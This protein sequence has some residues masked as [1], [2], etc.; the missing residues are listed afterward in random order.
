MVGWVVFNTI[1]GWVQGA[2]DLARAAALN[3]E[4]VSVLLLGRDGDALI[5]RA[6]WHLL[7]RLLPVGGG[8]SLAGGAQRIAIGLLLLELIALLDV[9]VHL[10]GLDLLKC[11]LVVA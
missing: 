9:Q 11:H 7:E 2:F 3:L 6:W 10:A 4:Q 5:Q 8:R 1:D